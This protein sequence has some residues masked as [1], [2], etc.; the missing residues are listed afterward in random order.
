MKVCKFTGG[1]NLKEGIMGYSSCCGYHPIKGQQPRVWILMNQEGGEKLLPYFTKEKY[2]LELGTKKKV[3][4]NCQNQMCPVGSF[5]M[6][7]AD[8][9]GGPNL[10]QS[11]MLYPSCCGYHPIIGQKPRVWTLMDREGGE[12]LLPYFSDDQLQL[13]LGSDKRVRLQCQ[14]PHCSVGSFEMKTVNFTGGPNLKRS[15]MRYPPCCNWHPI[16]GYK[17][18]YGPPKD[19]KD[20]K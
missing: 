5:E 1:P 12:N 10:I 3:R 20:K 2:Q 15:L 4:L 17:R 13:E 19:S 8:F 18:G 14:N 16:K 11:K 7:V 6:R 9:T